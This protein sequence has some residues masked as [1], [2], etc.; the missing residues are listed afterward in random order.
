MAKT[1]EN[2]GGRMPTNLGGRLRNTPLPVTNGLLPLFE[3]VVNSIQA[4]EE[5]GIGMK[6]ARVS[7]EVIRKLKQTS[8]PLP[9]N[10]KRGPETNEDIIGFK[11]TDKS[12]LRK[13]FSE[14]KRQRK[15]HNRK[16]LARIFS[17][18]SFAFNFAQT[19]IN[20]R[21]KHF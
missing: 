18:Y 15:I 9:H 17:I 14:G 5:A 16:I 19:L 12:P 6:D 13:A 21:V 8:L 3:A 10:K 4:I 1:G 2:F 20:S 7:V 11:I